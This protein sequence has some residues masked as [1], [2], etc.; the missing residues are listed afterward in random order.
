MALTLLTGTAT[1]V[2]TVAADLTYAVVDPRVRRGK[3]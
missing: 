1:L 3:A 2:G